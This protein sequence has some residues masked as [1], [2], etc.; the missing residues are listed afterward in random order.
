M[1]SVYADLIL[2]LKS[3]YHLVPFGIRLNIMLTS[4]ENEIQWKI[5]TPVK[6]TREEILE[7]RNLSNSVDDKIQESENLRSNLRDKL[8]KL[9]QS[10]REAREEANKV[11]H[12]WKLICT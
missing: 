12:V 6:G 1:C 3:N 7:L 10:I 9:K 2:V 5:I 4:V 11:S 8:G